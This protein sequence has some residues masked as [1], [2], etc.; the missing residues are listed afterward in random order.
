MR[1]APGLVLR[2]SDPSI[3]RFVP[4]IAVT[5]RESDAYVGAVDAGQAP[6]YRFP[7]QCPRAMAW[8]GPR[9]AADDRARV[10]GPGGGKRVHTG[11]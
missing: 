4:H 6:S 5:S 1:P 3:T 7:R 2:F 8:T 11:A 9:T 10:I